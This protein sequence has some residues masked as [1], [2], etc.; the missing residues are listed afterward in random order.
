MD[1]VFEVLLR[2]IRHVNEN[3]E[4]ADPGLKG[5][6]WVRNTNLEVKGM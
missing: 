6:L 3:I 4:E 1:K 2:H 5:K